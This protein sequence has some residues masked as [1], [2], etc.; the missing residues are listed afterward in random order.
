M[1]EMDTHDLQA[2]SLGRGGGD[3]TRCSALK[4]GRGEGIL[5]GWVYTSGVSLLLVE[6]TLVMACDTVLLFTVYI[7]LPYLKCSRAAKGYSEFLL[8]EDI[9]VP[10]LKG[11]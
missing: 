1:R 10:P 5:L 6:S 3:K 4:C 9:K 2:G 11:T 8:F 7:Y